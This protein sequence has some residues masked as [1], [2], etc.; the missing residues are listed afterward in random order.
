MVCNINLFICSLDIGEGNMTFESICFNG[1]INCTET[2]GVVIGTA[3][4]TTTGSLFLTFFMILIMILALALMFGIPL[5]Y[6]AILILPL[7]ITYMA[8]YSD[9]LGIGSVILIYLSIILT[10]N[11]LFK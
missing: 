2:I 1:F 9:F 5:E 6:M 4:S 8:Y 7:M 10:K 3:T 11:S